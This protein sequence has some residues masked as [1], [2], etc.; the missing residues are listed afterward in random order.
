MSINMWVYQ[1]LGDKHQLSWTSESQF[2][3]RLT[4]YGDNLVV[5][6]AIVAPIRVCLSMSWHCDL[7]LL[8]LLYSLFEYISH[9]TWPFSKNVGHVSIAVVKSIS[10][11]LVRNDIKQSKLTSRGEERRWGR[12]GRRAA[13]EDSTRG[14]FEKRGMERGREG[15]VLDDNWSSRCDRN[16]VRGQFYQ[17]LSYWGGVFWPKYTEHVNVLNR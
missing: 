6:D 4:V 5:F 2:K 13:A 17:R 1:Q 8:T 7:W 12:E 3:L 15:S 10:V 16:E 9:N 11:W 14:Q